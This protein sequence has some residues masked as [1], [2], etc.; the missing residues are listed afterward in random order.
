MTILLTLGLVLYLLIKPPI[1]GFL[2]CLILWF[3]SDRHEIRQNEDSSSG[4]IKITFYFYQVAELLMDTSIE[5]RLKVIPFLAFLIS[6]FNF[7]VT[8]INNKIGC[9]FAGLTAVTK[10]LFLSGNVVLAMANVFIVY[11]LH[12]FI[13]MLRQKEKPR[14]MHYAA[15]FMEVLLL[16]YERLAETSLKLMH[17][18]SIGS[19]KWLCIDA[20]IPCL[21]WWQYVLLAYIVMFV[22]PFTFVLYWGSLKLSKSSITAN[23][24]LAACVLPFPFLIYWICQT[25]WNRKIENVSVS[26]Q[27]VSRD[28]LEILVEPFRKG[29]LYWE[30][31]LIGRRFILLSF[32]TFI[33]DRMLRGVCMTSACFLMTIHH[34]LKKPYKD[35]LANKSET[36]SLVVLTLIVT[37]NLPKAIFFSFGVEMS[38][39]A[40]NRTN[41]EM[42]KWIEV[43]ALVFIPAFFTLL[44]TF[45]LLSP[46]SRFGLFL[47]KYIRRLYYRPSNWMTEAYRPLI[48]TEES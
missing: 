2:C 25:I 29:T 6:A 9:P 4:F 18:V 24:F 47:F 1:L 26:N 42:L 11:V 3:R 14:L 41:L 39:D 40:S 43:G 8:N 21:Q 38:I 48:S 5:N 28:V 34:I 7:H 37:I 15:V 33:T 13:N 31:V 12:M 27:E 36:L 23:E 30:S 19:T 16:G 17:C 35:P 46:L 22:L 20:N 45:A 44:V 32:R 10:E